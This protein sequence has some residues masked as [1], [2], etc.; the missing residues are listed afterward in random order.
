MSERKDFDRGLIAVGDYIKNKRKS[1]G[2]AYSSRESFITLCSEKYFQSKQ[3][4]SVRHLSSIEEGKSWPS[5]PMLF[6]LSTALEEDPET[7]CSEIIN[8]Y[9]KYIAQ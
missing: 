3:W 2:V 4:I 7:L 1:L 6:Y 5:I 8:I 9:K